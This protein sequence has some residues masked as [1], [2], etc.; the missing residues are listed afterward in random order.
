[1]FSWLGI[2]AVNP[3]LL[4]GSAAIAAPIIIHL[5]ARRKFR[6]IDW[7]A[8]EFLLDA[9]RRNRR[10]I[11]LEHLILLL[12]R[13]LAVLL[14]AFLVAR[15]FHQATGLASLIGPQPRTERIVLLDDSPSMRLST[16]GKT[17]FER[18]TAALGDFVKQAARQRPG[19]TIT[20]LR[21]SRPG[22]PV[23]NGQY[24]DQ[25][26]G[27]LKTIE[28][29]E[30]SDVAADLPRALLA[31]G[32]LIDQAEE[33]GAGQVNRVVYIVSDLR[34]RDWPVAEDGERSLPLLLKQLGERTDGVVIVNMGSEAE[35]NLAVSDI[36]PQDKTIVA[37]VPG[38]YE[39]SVTNYGR[40]EAR[41]VAV[42]F[43]SGEA[44]PL[45]GH[46]DR[47]GPG[48]TASVPF[49]FTFAEPGSAA[50]RAEIA[51]DELSID[52][53]RTLVARVREGVRVL[54]VD[55]DPSSEPARSETHFLGKALNPPDRAPAATSSKSSPRTSSS[56]R[57]SP[58][59]R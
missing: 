40:R 46:I 51:P 54:V 56:R 43:T 2:S 8:M 21:A 57:T 25:A 9:N 16:A 19:D 37:G 35:M 3:L 52:N 38:R 41:D 47:I 24:F 23:I 44:I 36:E 4:W 7:A 5:L 28:Q 15:L 14:I 31:V 29:L 20:L 1:M 53:A 13:C 55:G 49:A 39:V 10:R 6:V 45:V 32:D 22:K 18:S 12:L 59:T 42:S 34:Q 27:V 30:P 58:R 48:S 33:A 50:L 17:V 26:D 11:Q